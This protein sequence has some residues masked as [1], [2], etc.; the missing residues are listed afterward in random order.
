MLA[1]RRLKLGNCNY[2]ERNKELR[3]VKKCVVSEIDFDKIRHV[4][5]KVMQLQQNNR[6]KRKA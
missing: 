4:R 1:R 5:D 6:F 3:A 2:I